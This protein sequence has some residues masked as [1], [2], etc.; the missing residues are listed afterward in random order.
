[1]FTSISFVRPFI[2]WSVHVSWQRK[3]F[4]SFF[5]LYFWSTFCIAVN[6]TTGKRFFDN[7]FRVQFIYIH[8]N[9]IFT[10][11]RAEFLTK[12]RPLGRDS[13][14][15]EM[16][17]NKVHWNH[18]RKLF[19]ITIYSSPLNRLSRIKGVCIISK[20]VNLFSYHSLHKTWGKLETYLFPYGSG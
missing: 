19:S 11:S 10:I 15:S 13:K 1:M 18:G 7:I 20:R 5:V 4:T 14:F 16:L 2:S 3:H 6:N 12:K 9:G 8:S 17:L